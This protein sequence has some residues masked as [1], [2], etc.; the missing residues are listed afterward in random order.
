MGR[1]K[2]ALCVNMCV[3]LLRTSSLCVCVCVNTFFHLFYR[4]HHTFLCCTLVISFFS[5]LGSRRKNKQTQ[6]PK[7]L[8]AVHE[9]CSI[10]PAKG[11]TFH[12]DW[13]VY[14]WEYTNSDEVTSMNRRQL[15]YTEQSLHVK[16]P[17]VGM[18]C[19]IPSLPVWLSAVGLGLDGLWCS[20]WL[21]G[22]QGSML[23][24]ITIAS[25]WLLKQVY[26]IKVPRDPVSLPAKV[27][28]MCFFY[29]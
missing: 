9:I 16:W 24:P 2:Q 19:K 11:I 26:S 12:Y 27:Q 23:G 1:K 25:W 4:D 18:W 17:W 22:P 28:I 8:H 29:K 7:K 20:T 10:Q 6:P 21:W 15:I 5:M 14:C 13:H 3:F